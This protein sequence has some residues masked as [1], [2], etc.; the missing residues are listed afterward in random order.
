MLQADGPPDMAR[1]AAVAAEYGLDVDPTSVPR[2]AQT[3]GLVL[4]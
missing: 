2:L 1:L 4:A 3:H